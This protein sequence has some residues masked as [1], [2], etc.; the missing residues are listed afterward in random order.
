MPS[1]NNSVGK[2]VSRFAQ[3]W[4][5]P[6][7]QGG[8]AIAGL[9]VDDLKLAVAADVLWELDGGAEELVSVADELGWAR[10]EAFVM[11]V[12]IT[13]ENLAAAVE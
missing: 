1:Q 10:V 13:G 4:F 3:K 11:K 7:P 6:L 9:A 12:I 5:R 2:H 8:N